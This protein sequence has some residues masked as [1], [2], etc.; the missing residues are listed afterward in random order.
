M[1]MYRKKGKYSRIV[2]T[3]L[4]GA[5]ILTCVIALSANRNV[6]AQSKALDCT[7]YSTESMRQEKIKLMNLFMESDKIQTI[8]STK[9]SVV[10]QFT[11]SYNKKNGSLEDCDS[12]N[13]NITLDTKKMQ[14]I[15]KTQN[16]E[17]TQGIEKTQ[18][19]EKVQETQAQDTKKQDVNN[20]NVVKENL[21]NQGKD[22]QDTTCTDLTKRGNSIRVVTQGK[23]RAEIEKTVKDIIK[24]YTNEKGNIGS[25]K[26][27]PK[28][29]EPRNPSTETP[30]SNKDNSE[31]A[32]SNN[33]NSNYANQVLDL[34]NEERGKAGL[35][36]LKMNQKASQA[37]QI[38]AKEIVSSFSHTR[39]NGTSPFT[40]LDGVGATYRTAGENI[41]YG[42][43]SPTEVMNGWMNSS[44]HRANIL[45]KEFKEIG[46]AAYYENG[47]YYWVQLFIG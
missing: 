33:Y 44:G 30:D 27:E 46:I 35:S 36:S 6:I 41:A 28:K 29:E 32:S 25:N 16:T 22:K 5:G 19:T 31:K 11:E 20:T 12:T 13:S 43:S 42:Q 37:A 45:K 34:V 2:T 7:Q 14:D 9:D 3:I 23:S 10:E 40:A 17:K 15:E 18:D 39:P 24:N 38:R 26:E 21:S 47:R 4:G 8:Q 1:R